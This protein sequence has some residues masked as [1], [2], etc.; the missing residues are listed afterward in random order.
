MNLYSCRSIRKGSQVEII[1]ADTSLHARNEYAK[2][3]GVL[4]GEV[5]ASRIWTE[6]S[7]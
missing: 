7:A 6:A 2:R 3:F 1:Q 5:I 4:V